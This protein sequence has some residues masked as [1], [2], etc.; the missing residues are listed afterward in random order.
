MHRRVQ[1]CE[2]SAQECT[3]MQRSAKGCKMGCARVY[4]SVKDY[5]GCTWGVQECKGV[6]RSVKECKGV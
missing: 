6:R 3:R 5:T 1:E 4:G 2:R